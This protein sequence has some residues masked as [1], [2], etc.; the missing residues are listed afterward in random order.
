MVDD[1]RHSGERLARVEERLNAVDEKLTALPKIAESINAM[2]IIM[3]Q[4]NGKRSMARYIGHVAAI[5]LGGILGAFTGH[6][7]GQ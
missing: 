2:Q 1:W 6:L 7:H 3:A 4:D 5:A